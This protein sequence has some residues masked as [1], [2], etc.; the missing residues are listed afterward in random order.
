MSPPNLFI[1]TPLHNGWVHHEFAGGLMQA[2]TA[3]QF[4]WQPMNGT[5]LPRQRDALTALFLESDC[6]HLLWIDSDIGWRAGD[7]QSL[8]DSGKDFIGGPYSRKIPGGLVPTVLTG[9]REGDLF[10]ATHVATGFLLVTRA[11]VE[12]MSA[13]FA[14]TL[15]YQDASSRKRMVALF[16]QGLGEGTEDLSFCRRWREC[17]GQVWLHTG[18]SLGHF[19]GN[20]CFMPDLVKL[21]GE[22]LPAVAAE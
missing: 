13:H 18:I 9:V 5:S 7:V 22:A 19:D 4:M 6:T 10:E 17:G 14:S 21:R 3:L 8:L 11:A 16:Q 12:R 2:A 15:S 1:A 20:T